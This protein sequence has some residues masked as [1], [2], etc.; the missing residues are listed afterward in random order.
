M[1]FFST[2]AMSPQS[3]YMK[4]LASRGCNLFVEQEISFKLDVAVFNI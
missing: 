2:F 3:N 4:Q 1:R